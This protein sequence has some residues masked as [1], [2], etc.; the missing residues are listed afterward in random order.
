[1]KKK[2]GFTEICKQPTVSKTFATPLWP[3]PH[4]TAPTLDRRETE[5]KKEVETE[6]N[7]SARR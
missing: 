3:P 2:K 5:S 4:Q 6:R 7:I 1:M